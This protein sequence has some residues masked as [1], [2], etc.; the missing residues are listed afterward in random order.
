LARVP[1]P[2]VIDRH[3]RGASIIGIYPMLTDETCYFLAI[4][5]D[6]EGWE[7]DI[8][9]IREICKE[10]KHPSL[11]FQD[12]GMG[13]IYGFSFKIRSVLFWQESLDLFQKGILR[14]CRVNR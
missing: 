8:C 12:R 11:N 4:K 2:E 1:N 3:L 5:F 9:V 6:G 7:K 10:K 14:R 13:H